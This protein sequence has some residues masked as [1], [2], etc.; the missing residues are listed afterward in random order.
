MTICFLGPANSAH[1]AKWS[2][3]FIS[4]GHKVDIVSFTKGSVP[5]ATI[6]YVDT[7][8]EGDSSD[9]RKIRYLFKAG[10]IRRLINE[11]HPDIINVHY[12]TSYGT[13]AALAGLKNYVLSVWG[14]DIYDFPN[15]GPIHKA[16]LKFS[17]K[18]APYLFSTSKAMADEAAKYTNKPFEITPFGVDMELFS[19]KK[20]NRVDE[21]FVVGIVK[22]LSYVYGIDY[23][24]KAVAIVRK[25]HPEI[26]LK[27]RI[28]GKGPDED[29][30]RK[31]AEEY[32]ID[33]ITT[34]LGYV[35]QE[36]AAQEWAN[37]DLAVICSLQ[38]SF[39]VSAV[40]AQA[41]GCPVI[42]SDIEG[43]KET[44]KPGMTSVVVESKN[45]NALADAILNMYYSIDE[46]LKMGKRGREF[47]AKNYEYN[48]CFGM[49]ENLF[50]D[51][52]GQKE[53]KP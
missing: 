29:A 7:G 13:V 30:L 3:F 53:S 45:E 21:D 42:I 25:E 41:C 33:D 11:L 5:G 51:I 39:G 8:A 23:L 1:I 22:G 43:L 47:I 15:R 19:P 4:H 9:A 37:M 27:L 28:A 44:T 50:F 32:D 14:S 26:P 49:I 40:E 18:R 31:L 16:M 2:G 24:I 20:R 38:E 35:P 10:E 48:L 6:H 52:L 36:Q 46:R 34:W 12:A 17:L